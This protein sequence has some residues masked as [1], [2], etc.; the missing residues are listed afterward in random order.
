MKFKHIKAYMETAIAFSKCSN[1]VRLK[2]G[3]VLVKDN[4][5]ISVGYNAFPEHIRTES[6]ELPDGTTDPRVRHAEKN[7]MLRLAK[8]TESAVGSTLFCT[9]WCCLDCS[10]DIVDLKIKEV[11]V[12]HPYRSKEGLEYLKR[13]GVGVIHLNPKD[14]I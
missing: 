8:T 11:Y 6:L 9:H 1:G 13:N 7:A 14:F 3:A 10:L 4:N 12:L 2:V 5:I